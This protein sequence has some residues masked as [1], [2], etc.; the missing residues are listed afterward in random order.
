MEFAIEFHIS[1][2]QKRDSSHNVE[3]RGELQMFPHTPSYRNKKIRIICIQYLL[4]SNAVVQ[5][6]GSSSNHIILVP[7]KHTEL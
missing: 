1:E 6:P 2:I 7:S 3:Q 4:R 5:C